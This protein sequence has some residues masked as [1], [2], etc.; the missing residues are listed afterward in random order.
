M[1]ILEIPFAYLLHWVLFRDDLSPVGLLGV[2][3]VIAGSA[4]NLLRQL[5]A[6][7]P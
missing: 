3:L 1:T 6:S 4:I 5:R 7:K 2:A